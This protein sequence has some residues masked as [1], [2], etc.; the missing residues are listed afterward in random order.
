MLIVIVIC[1][2]SYQYV[3]II[4]LTNPMSEITEI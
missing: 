1:Y 3:L 2:L 4:T